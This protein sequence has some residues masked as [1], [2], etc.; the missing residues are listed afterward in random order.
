[1]HAM[2]R[3]DYIVVGSGAGGSAAAYRLARAGADVLLLERGGHL[4]TDGSTF[5]PEQVLRQGRFRSR[6]QWQDRHGRTLVPEECFNLGGKTRWYGA[7]LARFAREEF[8]ADPVRQ[9]DAWPLSPDQLA[10]YYAE[11]EALLGARHFEP[12]PDLARIC[13]RLVRPGTGWRSEPLLLG[14]AENILD[15]HREAAYFDGFALN[16]GL[17]ADAESRLLARVSHQPNFNVMVDVHVTSLLEDESDAR[18]VSGVRSSDGRVFH[19]RHLV[20][21]AGAMHSP[22]LLQD[23][24]ATSGLQDELPGAAH[25]G[26]NYKRHVLSAVLGFAARPQRDVL[27]KTQLLLNSRHPHSSVQPLGG[28]IDREIVRQALPDWLPR[29]VVEAFS[30]RVYGFFLQTEEGSHSDN[31][32]QAGAAAQLPKLDYDPTR[33]PEAEREHRRLVRDFKRGLLGAGLLPFAQRIGLAGSA[34]AVGTLR[35][36]ATPQDSVVDADGRVHGMQNL[37]VAD[38]SVLPRIGRLNPAL[39]IYAWSLRVADRLLGS[40]VT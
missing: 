4:P 26:R 19:C 6:E 13:R 11:A 36:G 16:G 34:H 14:L 40:P 10:P 37:Y 32:V 39:T 7:A 30:R 28:S 35:A 20:L 38:G 33:L 31:R 21:A 15:F 9:F 3:H 8:A 2:H 5:D 29:S 1:M 18:F 23:Y 22:R 12:E 27:R 24:L 25:V 17:K